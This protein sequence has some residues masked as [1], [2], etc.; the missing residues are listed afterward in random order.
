MN[1]CRILSLLF[2]LLYMGGLYANAEK[3]TNSSSIERQETSS[4][5]SNPA[6]VN[7]GTGSGIVQQ[8]LEKKFGIQDNHGISVQGAWMGD[9]NSLFT[10]GIPNAKD[11]TSN[12]VGLL[13]LTIDMERFNGWKGGLFSAQ[14]LQQNAQ[15]TNGPAG[16]IQGYNS[17]PDVSPYNRSE[18]YALWYRQALFDDTFFLR[19]GKTITTL[20]FNNVVKP[21]QLSKSDPNIPAVTS[22]IYTP[23][24]I[25]PAVDG[26]M[27]GYTNTAYGLTA[28]YTPIKSWYVSYGLYDGSLASGKQTG[29]SG[30]NF[31]GNYF[32]VGETG[33]AWLL[34]KDKKPGTIGIGLWHQTG[35]IKQENLTQSGSTGGYLFG[36]QRLW[37]RHP[38]YDI[39]GISGF[40]QYGINN[41]R[42][43]P[44]KQSI[45]AGLTAFGL[46]ANREADSIGA[47]FSLAWLNQRITNRKT[48]LMF[49]IYYQAKL[50]K[51]VYLEPVLSYIPTPGQSRQLNPATAGTLRAIVLL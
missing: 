46:V 13:D 36:S 12:S 14:F 47:G 30:P 22:L 7:V 5:S 41:S 20:D 34:G 49:Q 38:G 25:S 42:V 50:L 43:L 15:N 31:N 24:F 40:Y 21:V 18:L 45:G 17:L 8:Y 35:L 27:P 29:L 51:F 33:S 19:L 6:A 39:S 32:Q 9:T 1:Y 4:I 28:T 44:M 48:E 26:L 2:Y 37:Y 11:N 10:G 3:P 16:V 23:I